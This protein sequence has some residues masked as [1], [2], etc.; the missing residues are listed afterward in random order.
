MIAHIYHSF[1]CMKILDEL[2]EMIQYSFRF[3]SP[4]KYRKKSY[5][6]Q[7]FQSFLPGIVSV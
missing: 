2:Y 3:F 6:L 4:I 7:I 5:F 1:F